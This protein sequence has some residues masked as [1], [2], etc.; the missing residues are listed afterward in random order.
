MTL[1]MAML[2]RLAFRLTN[3]VIYSTYDSGVYTMI[4]S[5]PF[6]F[7]FFHQ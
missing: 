7:D 4:S 3:T 6:A 1:H 5:D 2:N